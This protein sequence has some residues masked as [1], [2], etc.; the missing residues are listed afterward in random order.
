MSKGE[1]ARD[2]ISIRL[3]ARKRETQR[4]INDVLTFYQICCTSHMMVNISTDADIKQ[5][6]LDNVTGHESI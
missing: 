6:A 3:S 5:Q 2:V 1:Q 4:P